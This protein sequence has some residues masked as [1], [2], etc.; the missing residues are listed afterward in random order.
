MTY[1]AWVA[2]FIEQLSEHFNLAGWIITVEHSTDDPAT[3]GGHT[4]AHISVNSTYLTAHVTVFNQAKL[5][6]ESGEHRRLVMA[7]THELVHIF[8]DPF[9]D[10]MHEF[11]SISRTPEFMGTVE[12]QTQKLTMVLLKNLPKHI[13]PPFPRKKK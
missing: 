12:R 11:L 1:T 13:I 3:E 4:Y 7:L 9:Q 6:F 2:K 5:D 10:I 8:I